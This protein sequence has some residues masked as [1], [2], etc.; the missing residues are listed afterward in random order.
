M[1]QKGLSV[2]L[3]IA[4]IM[5]VAVAAI[6]GRLILKKISGNPIVSSNPTS[7]ANNSC[8]NVPADY[9]SR[10]EQLN[11]WLDQKLVE[12][13]P[14]EYKPMNFAAYHTFA[15]FPNVRN[16]DS[17][18]LKDYTDGLEESGAD[19]IVVY[20]DGTPFLQ[21]DNAIIS[22][23]DAVV[24]KIKSDGKKLYIAY[25]P[26]V[27][28][29]NLKNWETYKSVEASTIGEIMKKYAPDSF[30]VLNEPS[31]IERELSFKPTAV[32]WAA[33]ASDSADLVKNLS[34]ETKINIQITGNDLSY[35]SSLIN[36]NNIE[37]VGFNIYGFNAFDIFTPYIASVKSAG[38]TP[39]LSE[40]WKMFKDNQKYD[41]MDTMDA[42]WV[43]VAAYYAQA[44]DMSYVNPFFTFYFF[45]SPA[46][47]RY[48]STFLNKL[49]SNIAAGNR[50]ES[51][52]EYRDVINETKGIPKR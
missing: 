47:V 11:S 25:I 8:S 5:F 13:K 27:K 10:C 41:G 32:Q 22:K 30:V 7:S 51:F 18:L 36:A 46:D 6:G 44:N 40:T 37:G 42:K 43:R 14:A 24:A 48:Q 35:F 33:L 26:D 28:G 15:S 17:D 3:I 9:K 34:P 1:N 21:N 12:W 16:V 23:W 29:S 19:T 50:M 4:I 52:L 2:I 38:K 31:T 39:M 20:M 45:V 49:G